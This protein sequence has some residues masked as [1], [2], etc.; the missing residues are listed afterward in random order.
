MAGSEHNI[1]RCLVCGLLLTSKGQ[2]PTCDDDKGR[3]STTVPDLAISKV[4][5]KKSA[6]KVEVAD[7][8]V[9]FQTADGVKGKR[10]LTSAFLFNKTTKERFELSYAVT[11]I[12]RDRNNNISI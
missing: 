1:E 9:D 8:E 5:S 4:A 7:V 11:K 12:G 2:C 10:S 6:S 3:K